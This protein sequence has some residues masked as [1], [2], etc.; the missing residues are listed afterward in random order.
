MDRKIV[1]LVVKR[2][3]KLSNDAQLDAAF[4]MKQTPQQRIAAVTF[5]SMLS[6]KPGQSMDKSFVAKFKMHP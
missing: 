4:W 2:P 6:V 1:P 5:L 3:I